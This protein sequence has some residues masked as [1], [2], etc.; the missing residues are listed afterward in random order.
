MSSVRCPTPWRMGAALT[1]ARRYALFRLVGIAG[2]DDLD[3]PDLGANPESSRIEP[4]GQPVPR[5][6]RA[7]G[8]RGRKRHPRTPKFASSPPAPSAA[9][10]ETCPIGHGPTKSGTSTT[11]CD[12]RCLMPAGRSVRGAGGQRR[13]R[14]FLASPRFFF[15]T[16]SPAR[17]V[18]LCR[19][20]TQIAAP[21]KIFIILASFCQVH[22]Q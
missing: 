21:L 19:V 17:A 18:Q 7:N 13:R 14:D 22:N 20:R 3:A 8:Q 2:E 1:Y 4:Y 9:V 6:D 15:Q 11:E 10:T 12:G 5:E 16:F